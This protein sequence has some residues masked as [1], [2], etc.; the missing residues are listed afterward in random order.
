MDLSEILNDSLKLLRNSDE[1]RPTH[2]L[3]TVFHPQR[4]P[5]VVDSNRMRQV[6]W[7]LAKNALK[8]MPGGGTLTVKALGEMDGQVLV[9]FS[10]QGIGMGGT[11][12]TKNFQPFHGSFQSGTGL[13]LAIVY[14]IVQEHQGRIRIKSRRGAGTEV[15]IL[16]PKTQRESRRVTQGE[17]WTGF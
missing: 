15:Q 17:T 11:E 6:F 7:N 16:L 9:S 10:D 3:K 4:I 12:V 8:A 13:G 1:F 5:V 14:R 2:A